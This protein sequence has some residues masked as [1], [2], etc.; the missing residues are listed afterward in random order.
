[1][2]VPQGLIPT[3]VGTVQHSIFV[4][5]MDRETKCTLSKF[6]NDTKLCD[7]VDVLEGKFPCWREG[8]HPEG[9]GQA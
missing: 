1:M 5:G 6:A 2:G 7:A 8:S 9:P 3:E 4:G